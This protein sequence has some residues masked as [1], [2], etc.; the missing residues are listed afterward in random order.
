MLQ[1]YEFDE[2]E[3]LIT[4]HTDFIALDAY[5]GCAE[6]VNTWLTIVGLNVSDRNTLLPEEERLKVKREAGK[7]VDIIG[8][9]TKEMNLGIGRYA[10]NGQERSGPS[11]GV[12]RTKSRQSQRVSDQTK[13]ARRN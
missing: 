11:R 7:G 2:D 5:A 6:A 8:W 1:D 12:K 10:L 9:L 4:N 3:C 13:R